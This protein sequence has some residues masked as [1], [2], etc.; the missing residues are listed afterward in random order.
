MFSH[1]GGGG[2]C[3]SSM[4]LYFHLPNMEERALYQSV[5]SDNKFSY[6]RV[7]L[8][9]EYEDLVAY[10]GS[11]S[12]SDD[13]FASSQSSAPGSLPEASI[14]QAGQLHPFTNTQ[15]P[16]FQSPDT[17]EA[18]RSGLSSPAPSPGSSPI[19]S[20]YTQNGAI[21]ITAVDMNRLTPEHVDDFV[22][23][24]LSGQQGIDKIYCQ[25]CPPAKHNKPRKDCRPYA[26]KVNIPAS[27]TEA[28]CSSFFMYTGSHKVSFLQRYVC[29]KS[30]VR[31]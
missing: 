20:A 7:A 1:L 24:H 4:N 3:V 21:Y 2:P 31:I 15:S 8:Y 23:N 10:H 26:L 17:P 22:D 18:S 16:F 6:Q 19:V 12:S 11:G 30:D 5:F 28:Q 25:L 27:G 9:P 13:S 29:L 14:L